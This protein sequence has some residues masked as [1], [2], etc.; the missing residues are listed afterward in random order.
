MC[1]KCALQTRL[2]IVPLRPVIPSL[3]SLQ[4]LGDNRD[5][6]PVM[7]NGVR[8]FFFL[9]L[10]EGGYSRENS[11]KWPAAWKCAQFVDIIS[12]VSTP[13]EVSFSANE[14]QSVT[15]AQAS[16]AHRPV[17]HT[18]G[19]WQGAPSLRG[20]FWRASANPASL[21]P[22]NLSITFSQVSCWINQLARI[23]S[24]CCEL[25]LVKTWVD[26]DPVKSK[27]HSKKIEPPNTALMQ[28]FLSSTG[29][30]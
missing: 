9:L 3:L 24:D 17:R 21:M 26:G 20:P 22:S 30:S 27:S 6:C 25:C 19:A 12:L 11:A 18:Y 16:C 4:A 14:S 15:F 8:F 28:D 29:C 23:V 7:V 5:R 13:K 2:V 1:R 10:R